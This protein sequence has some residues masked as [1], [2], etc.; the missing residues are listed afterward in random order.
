MGVERA[1]AGTAF[2]N[3]QW[4]YIPLMTIVVAVAVSLFIWVAEAVFPAPLAYW[5]LGIKKRDRA[6]VPAAN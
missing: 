1:L 5:V 3:L 2:F 4:L 6:P